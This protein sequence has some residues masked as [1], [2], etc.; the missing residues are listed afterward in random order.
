MRPF[1]SINGPTAHL[2]E[3][4]SKL[5]DL[6]MVWVHGTMPSP[7]KY[8]SANK[9]LFSWH[10]YYVSDWHQM[11]N[12]MKCPQLG[13]L[14]HITW[15]P[16]IAFKYKILENSSVN[17]LISV[18]RSVYSIVLC[19]ALCSITLYLIGLPYMNS[20]FIIS[21]PCAQSFQYL[22]VCATLAL[23]VRCLFMPANIAMPCQYSLPWFI[24]PDHYVFDNQ[25]HKQL[26]TC[27]P[28]GNLSRYKERSLRSNKKCKI[29]YSSCRPLRARVNKKV[30]REHVNEHL[31]FSSSFFER[32]SPKKYFNSTIFLAITLADLEAF[33][34][35]ADC[36][37]CVIALDVC[38]ASVVPL[39]NSW[40]TSVKEFSE[41][42]SSSSEK[43]ACIP[44]SAVPALSSLLGAKW[45]WVRT[46]K[47]VLQLKWLTR[48]KAS[49]K[50]LTIHYARHWAGFH[51]VFVVHG[52][53]CCSETSIRILLA[54]WTTSL[55]S[56]LSAVVVMLI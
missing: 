5:I 4:K 38:S 41:S 11:Q 42:H 32:S 36:S 3:L 30:E 34:R 48:P 35:D 6:N 53:T 14:E 55:P 45:N 24:S 49:V 33:T 23:W 8:T 21:Y 9:L 10:S 12:L 50:W 29:V 16:S 22:D 44:I 54:D 51:Q 19:L 40:S 18:N 26:C 47:W 17:L 15:T 1:S 2:K 37:C 25:S 28:S 52:S 20:R 43:S 13:F 46:P 56:V 31:R 39:E 7:S 27:L